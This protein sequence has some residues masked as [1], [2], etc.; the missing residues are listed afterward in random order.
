MIKYGRILGIISQLCY[1]DDFHLAIT[2][3]LYKK[4]QP[5][6]CEEDKE[7]TDYDDVRTLSTRRLAPPHLPWFAQ[8]KLQR[9]A[10]HRIFRRCPKISKMTPSCLVS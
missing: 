10:C 8:T 5:K 6:F 2:D 7:I 1:Y 3:V 4:Q 9:R